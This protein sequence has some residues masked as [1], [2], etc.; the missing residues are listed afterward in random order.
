MFCNGSY[1]IK[2]IKLNIVCV[3]SL[4]SFYKL[5]AYLLP[6][7]RSN[8]D[9][10]IYLTTHCGIPMH[11]SPLTINLIHFDFFLNLT[12]TKFIAFAIDR[13]F[14]LLIIRKGSLISEGLNLPPFTV[15]N[16][17]TFSAQGRDLAHFFGNG[18]KVKTPSEIRPPLL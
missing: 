10:D 2:Q 14:W 16:L 13:M 3:S 12:T 11:P 9:A 18:T 1:F 6:F 17:F 15:N 7:T 8:T 4:V 5:N